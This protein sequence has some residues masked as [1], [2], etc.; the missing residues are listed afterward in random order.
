VSGGQVTVH[1]EKWWDGKT[2]VWVAYDDRGR[3]S[4]AVK[5]FTVMMDNPAGGV[6]PRDRRTVYYPGRIERYIRDGGGWQPFELE[7]ERFP[8]PWVKRDGSPLGLPVIHYAFPRFGEQQYGT[9]ELAGGFLAN[10]DHINDMQQ[11]LTAS[12]RLLGFQILWSTGIDWTE[13]TPSL[14]PGAFLHADAPDANFG[15][16]PAG[17]LKQIRDAHATKLQTIAR[18]TMTPIHI[19]SGGTW[20]AG[21]A[22]VQADKPLIAKCMR[23]MESIG[24][25]HTTKAHRATEM[26][27]AFGGAGL[28]EDAIITP[29]FAD[30]EQ[31]DQLAQAELDDAVAKALISFEQLKS[32]YALLKAGMSEEEAD[33]FIEE[34]K[35]R[36]AEAAE[37]AIALAG[38]KGGPDEQATRGPQKTPT[39][40][41]QPARRP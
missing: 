32:K 23:L 15:A 40:G 33:A 18:M 27:N 41:R 6:V 5:D 25:S 10:Q 4:Y 38:A 21:I 26:A 14:E 17:D 11:D 19:I 12:A 9:S 24:P 16:I 37:Q 20:P 3:P 13:S 36:E 22:L 31:L 35:Q 28:N 34:R 39:S 1:S 29:V 7:G 30:P 8:V 2:G